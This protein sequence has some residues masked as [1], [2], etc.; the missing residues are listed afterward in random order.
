MVKDIKKGGH[1]NGLG[2]FD[3]ALELEALSAPGSPGY[4]YGNPIQTMETMNLLSGRPEQAGDLMLL[5]V[6]MQLAQD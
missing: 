5:D 3:T 1:G 6:E 4:G 2:L